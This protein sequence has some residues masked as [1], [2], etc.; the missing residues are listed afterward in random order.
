MLEQCRATTNNAACFSLFCTLFQNKSYIP[1]TVSVYLNPSW[2]SWVG[3]T[4]LPFKQFNITSE[5]C[6]TMWSRGDGSSALLCPGNCCSNLGTFFFTEALRDRHPE[7]ADLQTLCLLIFSTFFF[8][9]VMFLPSSWQPFAR[10][11]QTPL[12]HLRGCPGG[13]L[14]R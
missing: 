2:L 6:N 9:F 3:S 10:R 14:W 4:P 7:T 11:L 13:M 8:L 5:I 12:W 1:I